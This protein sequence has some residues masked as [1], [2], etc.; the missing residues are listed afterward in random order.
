MLNNSIVA[1][2]ALSFLSTTALAERPEPKTFAY[3][4]VTYSFTVKEHSNGRTIEGTSQTRPARFKLIVS[5]YFV[6]GH[7]DGNPV[8][9]SRKE[10][11]PLRGIVEVASR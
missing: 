11:A 5:K 1:T 6:D 2:I 9:F 10:I 3:D 8:R 4:G 7:F